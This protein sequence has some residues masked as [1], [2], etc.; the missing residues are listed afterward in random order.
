MTRIFIAKQVA[1]SIQN[2][3][4]ISGNSLK[5]RCLDCRYYRR[6]IQLALPHSTTHSTIHCASPTGANGLL[7]RYVRS[8]NMSGVI[9]NCYFGC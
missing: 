8:N 3:A 5:L 4:D 7:P 1:A 6:E 2:I 9:E